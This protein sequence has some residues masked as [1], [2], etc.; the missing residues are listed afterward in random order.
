MGSNSNTKIA[1][2]N[3]AATIIGRCCG[4]MVFAVMEFVVVITTTPTSTEY[5]CRIQ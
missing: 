5:G 1:A 4:V 2:A 3:T